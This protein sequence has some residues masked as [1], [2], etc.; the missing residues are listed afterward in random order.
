MLADCNNAPE[1]GPAPSPELGADAAELGGA[2][3]TIPAAESPRIRARRALPAISRALHDA[4]QLC[5]TATRASRTRIPEPRRR[6]WRITS[7]PARRSRCGSISPRLTRS[8]ADPSQ[9]WSLPAPI[10]TARPP[11]RRR[12]CRFARSRVPLNRVGR[13]HTA[14]QP[15]SLWVYTTVLGLAKCVAAVPWRTPQAGQTGNGGS[16]SGRI[17]RALKLRLYPHPHSLTVGGA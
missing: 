16:I 12:D 15:S 17:V 10:E 6:A 3:T 9:C 11:R 1:L 2:G 5:A 8:D 4:L 14:S 13:P 7:G